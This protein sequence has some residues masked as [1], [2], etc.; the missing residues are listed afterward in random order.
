MISYREVKEKI[1]EL[2][3]TTTGDI[4]IVRGYDVR[5][6][7]IA[8]ECTSKLDKDEIY[9]ILIK[10]NKFRNAVLPNKKEGSFKIDGIVVKIFPTTRQKENWGYIAE[11]IITIA[12]G[13]R[14]LHKNSKVTEK[15]Y[16]GLLSE[17]GEDIKSLK[18]KSPNKNTDVEDDVLIKIDIPSRKSLYT[19]RNSKKYKT[20]VSSA[21][22]YAN[23]TN[24]SI[25]S[26]A[27]WN[28]NRYDKINVD[29]VGK[30]GGKTDT[31]VEITDDKGKLKPVNINLSMKI[32]D[33]R[34]FGQSVGS[35]Y[36][37]TNKF[38]KDIF[39][40]EIGEEKAYNDLIAQGKE[41]EAFKLA[42]NAV[43]DK[44][45]RSGI[46]PEILIRGIKKH[47]TGGNSKTKILNLGANATLLDFEKL[48][49]WANKYE[50]WDSIKDDFIV[51]YTEY[52]NYGFPKLII[53]LKSYNGD[54][55][56]FSVRARIDQSTSK[57]NK[58]Y[59]HYIEKGSLMTQLLRIELQEDT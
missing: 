33:V 4:A 19:K 57:G 59:R 29:T 45:N 22:K 3:E 8:I 14:F 46:N 11:G 15:E 38:L 6:N 52:G 16:N 27:V 40:H 5:T 39:G 53:K 51:E 47:A 21:I 17:F 58:V 32:S 36:E 7:G 44:I 20:L 48:N 49:E 28:N 54:N 41:I 23:S 18:K 34:Q 31:K 37:I 13:C 42:Y 30:R 9:D 35:T 25:W 43:K 55:I 50:T 24:V 12:I 1:E 56:L 10:E 2:L 26:R